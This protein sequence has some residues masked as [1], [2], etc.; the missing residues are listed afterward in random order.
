M[1]TG[2]VFSLALY[3]RCQLRLHMSR[4]HRELPSTGVQGVGESQARVG[5]HGA[6]ALLYTA[7]PLSLR[8]RAGTVPVHSSENFL[9][10]GILLHAAH[11]QS[12]RT[13]M[14]KDEIDAT[15]DTTTSTTGI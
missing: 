9:H 4:I 2:T 13:C 6:L 14:T 1:H 8:F 11:A 15:D 10:H 7:S 3:K 12:V 5:A